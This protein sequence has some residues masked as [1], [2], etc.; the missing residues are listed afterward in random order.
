MITPEEFNKIAEVARR[1]DQNQS[2]RTHDFA[3]SERVAGYALAIANHYSQDNLGLDLAVAALCHDL[4]REGDSANHTHG[5]ASSNLARQ[6]VT[7]L[8]LNVDLDSILFAIE[9]HSDSRA[10]NGSL[11]I[12]QSYDHSGINIAIPAFLWDA[13]RLELKRLNRTKIAKTRL[14]TP[15]AKDYA[16]SDRHEANYEQKGNMTYVTDCLTP[17]QT[18]NT[19]AYQG[20]YITHLEGM[21]EQGLL[22]PPKLKE[23]A[24]NEIESARKAYELSRKKKNPYVSAHRDIDFTRNYAFNNQEHKAQGI[25]EEGCILGLALPEFSTDSFVHVRDQIPSSRIREIYV[26][27]TTALKQVEAL[28]QKYDRQDIQVRLLHA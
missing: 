13:D 21:F 1:L 10:P 20:T 8:G 23:L 17:T 16:N 19:D 22:S 2:S 18:A 24:D 25:E 15:F 3:H 27:D 9:H 7:E 12:A 4:G 11:P 28:C 26:R 5:Q 14:S 6:V